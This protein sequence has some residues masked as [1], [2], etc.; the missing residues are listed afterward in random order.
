MTIRWIKHLYP[1]PLASAAYRQREAFKVD[2]WRQKAEGSRFHATQSIFLRGPKDPEKNWD[3]DV[4]C[5]DYPLLAD[6]AWLHARNMIGRIRR[7]LQEDIR[8][9][10]IP[11][12]L[13]ST[14]KVY[15]ESLA[16]EN[17]IE[18]GREDSEYGKLHIIRTLLTLE[19]NPSAVIYVAGAGIHM[20]VGG[21]WMLHPLALHSM[22]NATGPYPV[23]TFIVDFAVET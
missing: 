21:L 18:W 4:E 10:N 2:N 11:V 15:I 8:V 17:V 14:G 23:V 6:K 5:V 22:L 19:T 16:A 12:V 20:E 9:N 7:A 1:A 3:S 13:G